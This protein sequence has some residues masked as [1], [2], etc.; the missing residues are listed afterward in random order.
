MFPQA[1]AGHRVDL[2]QQHVVAPEAGEVA[3]HLPRLLLLQQPARGDA[4]F[5]DQ[6]AVAAEVDIHH[7][8]VGVRPG[9][10]VLLGQGAAQPAVAALVMH[11]IDPQHGLR[12]VVHQ[13]EQL[14][15]SH[16]MRAEELQDEAFVAEFGPTMP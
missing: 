14:Q 8:D 6:L 5:E 7:L 11:G 12:A 2:A 4:V 16:E 10:V 1:G 15:L 9:R 13:V 3:Q